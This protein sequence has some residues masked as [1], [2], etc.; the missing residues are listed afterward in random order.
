MPPKVTVLPLVVGAAGASFDNSALQGSDT[1]ETVTIQLQA[2]GGDILQ[3]QLSKK[4]TLDLLKVLVSLDAA[5]EAFG[6]GE[7]SDKEPAEQ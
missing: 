7:G 1:P 2:L 5:R 6:L 4:G 3:L